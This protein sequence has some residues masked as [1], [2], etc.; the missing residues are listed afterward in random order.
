MECLEQRNKVTRTFKKGHSVQG[1]GD[2]G[3]LDQTA[4]RGGAK[5]LSDSGYILKTESKRFC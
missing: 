4:S 1:G 2:D 3:G 5:K